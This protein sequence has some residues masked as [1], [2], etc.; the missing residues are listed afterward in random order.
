MNEFN[1]C[2]EVNTVNQIFLAEKKTNEKKQNNFYSRKKNDYPYLCTLH[3]KIS[4]GLWTVNLFLFQ[5]YIFETFSI[6]SGSLNKA[7]LSV[8]VI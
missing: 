5:T 6:H 2:M 8:F 1:T 3:V 4:H 7:H